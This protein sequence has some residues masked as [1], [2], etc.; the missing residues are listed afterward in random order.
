MENLAKT[1]TAQILTVLKILAWVAFVGF[2][3]EAGAI[4][5]S[6]SMSLLNA[7]A[8]RDFYNGLDMYSLRQAN[9]WEFTGVVSFKVAIPAMKSYVSLLAI[10]AL[11]KVSLANPF[12][13]EVS[14]LLERISYVV[15]EIWVIAMANNAYLTWGLKSVDELPTKYGQY[16]PGE[17][18]FLAG[19]VFVIAQI[20]KRGVEIQSEN[21]LT[22]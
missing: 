12:T 18:I 6:Y 22:V 3:I 14:K 10:R 7:E 2:A 11:S 16:V 9:F 1:P 5:F 8:A 13:M 4:L 20:F 17:F 19:L 21:E 15:L